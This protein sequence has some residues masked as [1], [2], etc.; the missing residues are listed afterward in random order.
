[1]GAGFLWDDENVLE[2][3]AA[4]HC[5]CAKRHWI[6]HFNVVHGVL[7]E[8]QLKKTLFKKIRSDHIL[9]T[10]AH[11]ARFLD[12]ANTN[13]KLRDPSRGLEMWSKNMKKAKVV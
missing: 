7:H 4:Q 11:E 12:A 13:K 1:M 2:P 10:F 6:A 9:V 8:S 5:E 3:E